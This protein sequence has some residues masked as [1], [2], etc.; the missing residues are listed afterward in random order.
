M[1]MV[2]SVNVSNGLNATTRREEP[3]T[4]REAEARHHV[5]ISARIRRSRGRDLRQL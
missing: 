3:I 4:M 1:E 5:A 2:G